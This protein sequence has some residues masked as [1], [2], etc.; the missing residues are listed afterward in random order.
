[1][2]IGNNLKAI[3]LKTLAKK[4]NVEFNIKDSKKVLMLR[5]DRIGDMIIATPVF[6][7]LKREYP[8]IEIS[9]LASKSNFIVLKNNPYVDKVY[10]N[11]KNN[12]FLDLPTLLNLRKKRID[13]CFE[14]DHSIVRHAI[15]RLIIIKTALLNTN[16]E[17]FNVCR[18]RSTV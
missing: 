2:S 15:L 7:E 18:I 16:Y 11:N 1:M 8:D 3:L 10:V 6:R 13:V 12:F 5:Y 14:F 4:K 9:V 17:R